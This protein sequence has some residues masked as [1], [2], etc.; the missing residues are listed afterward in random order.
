MS[1]SA[2][3]DDEELEIL[4]EKFF[5]KKNS[6]LMSYSDSFEARMRDRFMTYVK[7]IREAGTSEENNQILRNTKI[8]VKKKSRRAM[9][10]VNVQ[11]FIDRIEL[12][13][14]D[15]EA[16]A[17]VIKILKEEKNFKQVNESPEDG[18]ITVNLPKMDLEKRF[19]LADFIESKFKNYQKNVMMVKNQ[20]MQQ[21]RAGLQN[22]FIFGPDAAKASKEIEKII[23]HYVKTAKLIFFVKHKA[24]LK[25]QFKLTEEDDII[26]A[27]KMSTV[28]HILD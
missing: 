28:A 6:E 16:R 23:D 21:I 14:A 17:A 15:A 18:L 22:E 5:F 20:S 12:R 24:I 11:A 4:L 26:L 9:D 1:N 27:R 19:E 25:N 8:I 13:S 7:E 2:S 3:M 10:L